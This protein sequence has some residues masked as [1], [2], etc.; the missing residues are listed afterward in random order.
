QYAT[1]RGTSRFQKE[2]QKD[3]V[4]H[5]RS[6]PQHPMTLGKVER[7]WGSIWREFLAR[8]Q[9]DDF[10]QARARIRLWIQYYNHKRPHQGIG[11]LCPADRFFEI[12][13]ELRE[14][15]EKGIRDNVLEMAL[16]GRPR[17][18]FYMVGRMQGQSVVLH[19]EKGKLKLSLDGEDQ[20]TNELEYDIQSE[21][22]PDAGEEDQPAAHPAQAGETPPALPPL[23]RGGEGPGSTG[24]LDGET[25]PERHLPRDGD[26]LH[27][28][29]E[30]A[31][32]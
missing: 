5:I 31:E 32:A 28:A 27:D 30:L 25:Q 3:R 9:F 16:R 20:T 2:M 26:Q 13:H 14:T 17:A 11:G 22:R 12:Q 15:L 10:E 8:A 18:P 23:Q 24:H 7:F 1:W 29:A 21:S 19:A 4:S 6:Q